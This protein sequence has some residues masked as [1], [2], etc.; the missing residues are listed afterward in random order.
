S[1]P[2][3]VDVPALEAKRR[4]ATGKSYVDVGFWGGAVPGNLAGLGDLY[5]AGVFGFKCFLVDSGVPEFPPLDP[6]GLDSALAAVA[7]PFLVHAENPHEIGKAPSSR[8]YRDFL[9]SRPDAA[10]VRAIEQ[11]VS[12]AR[13]AGARVHVLH[14]SSAQALATI[15]A[16][17]ADG[18]R[19][20]VETCPHYLSLHADA[21]PDGATQFKCCPP[22]RDRGNQ[23]ALWQALGSG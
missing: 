8:R 16:A 9:D 20:T 23:D 19:I 10:E 14:L 3:T 22:I 7:A 21:V 18:V 5:D 11:V 2:P 6:A 4:A 17:K 15:A 12:A 1:L 13:R